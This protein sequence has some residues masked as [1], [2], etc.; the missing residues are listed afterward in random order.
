MDKRNDG[1]KKDGDAKREK[2]HSRV[3]NRMRADT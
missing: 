1:Q 3:N 2:Q